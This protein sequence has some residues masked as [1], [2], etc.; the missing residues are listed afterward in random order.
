MNFFQKIGQLFVSLWHVLVP[1]FEAAA[2]QAFTDFEAKIT[3]DILKL[4]ADAIKSVP[5]LLAGTAARDAAK[6]TLIADLEATGQDIATWA[7]NELN[8]L[9]EVVYLPVKGGAVAAGTPVGTVAASQE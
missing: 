5:A 4:A 9:L 3:P 1:G 2:E 8:L 6:A 7:D